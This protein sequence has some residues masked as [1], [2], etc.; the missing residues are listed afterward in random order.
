MKHNN[1]TPVLKN[2]PGITS[3]QA[4]LL[5]AAGVRSADELAQNHPDKLYRWMTEVNLE[6]R[7]VRRMPTLESVTQWVFNARTMP[8]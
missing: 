3:S 7:I 2:I 8:A 5:E 1:T 4:T 6:Q